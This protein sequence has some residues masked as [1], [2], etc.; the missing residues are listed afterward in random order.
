MQK[1]AFDLSSSSK[2]SSVYQVLCRNSKTARRVF[3]KEFYEGGEQ[4]EIL[5]QGWGELVEDWAEVV[6]E[7]VDSFEEASDFVFGVF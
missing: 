5:V 7:E 3:G 4:V 6:F 2:V 1:A